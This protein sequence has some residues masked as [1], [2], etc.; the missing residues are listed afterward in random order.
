M[1][2]QFHPNLFVFDRARAA[3]DF[4]FATGGDRCRY[5]SKSRREK[6]HWLK[7]NEGRYRRIEDVLREDA[8]RMSSV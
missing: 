1:N 4:L 8:P 6:P 3:D 5:P 2:E 7:Q